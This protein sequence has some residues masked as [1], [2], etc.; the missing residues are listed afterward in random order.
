MQRF[1]LLAMTNERQN[2]M[3]ENK[4][5]DERVELY[6]PHGSKREDPNVII[7]INGVN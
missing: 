3:S 7:S 2:T 4:E 1:A 5:T 6:I